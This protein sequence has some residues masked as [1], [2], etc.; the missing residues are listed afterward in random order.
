MLIKF[1]CTIGNKEMNDI[2][3]IKHFTR[4]LKLKHKILK[5]LKKEYGKQLICIDC[6]AIDNKMNSDYA[7]TPSGF[8]GMFGSYW[9]NTLND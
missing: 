1:E 5:Q 2:K 7:N 9:F 6:L 4:P 8:L 3:L